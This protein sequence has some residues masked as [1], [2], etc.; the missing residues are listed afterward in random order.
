MSWKSLPLEMNIL[1]HF[2]GSEN[3]QGVLLGILGGS[4][5]PG[6]ANPDPF[7]T[8]ECHF[9]HPFSDLA[10]KFHTRFQTQGPLDS[11][12]R[13]INWR[14]CKAVVVYMQG[15][16]FNSFASNVIKLSANETTWSSLLA[17]T[18]ALILYFS[19]CKSNFGPETLPG[20]SRNRPLPSK[21]LCHHYLDYNAN[22]TIS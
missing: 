21:K 12:V 18:R 14:A 1:I 15:R 7:Q 19:I 6:P 8:K 11:K 16:G 5:L 4:V 3:P 22:K 13:I 2:K 20:L 17:R 9:Q 10:S